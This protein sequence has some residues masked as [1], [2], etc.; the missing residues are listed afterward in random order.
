MQWTLGIIKPDAVRENHSG[1][2]ISIIQKAGFQIKGMKLTRLTDAKVNLFYA[3]HK[4][5]EFFPSLYEY[6]TG[7]PIICMALQKENAI[8][9]FRALIGATDPAQAAPGTIR[10]LYGKSKTFNAVHGSDS[11]ENAQNEIA[12]MFGFGEI[13]G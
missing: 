12:I 13:I 2:I 1:D 6:M 11:A 8:E 3:I 9:D 10:N 7:G 5:K 4:D